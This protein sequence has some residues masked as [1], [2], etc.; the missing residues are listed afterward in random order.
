MRTYL[1]AHPEAL[2]DGWGSIDINESGLEE[3][4]TSIRTTNGDQVLAVNAK[5][6]VLLIRV[7][8]E[9]ARGVLAIG[10]DTT[11]LRLCPTESLGAAGQTVGTICD[12]NQGVLAI[13]GSAF[14]DTNGEENGGTSAMM[15]YQG[16]CVTRCSNT[17]LPDG[18]T[19]PSA[20]VYGK[21]E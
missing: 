9:N 21:A 14:I 6:G 4:G 5:D 8:V 10:K 16:K 15:Y 19:L 7:E 11:Q 17:D 2:N 18:R 13:T 20:W 12:N 1:D 3:A